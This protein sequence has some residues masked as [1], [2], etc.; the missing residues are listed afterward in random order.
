[1]EKHFVMKKTFCAAILFDFQVHEIVFSCEWNK[2]LSETPCAWKQSVRNV[3]RPSLS[4]YREK[5]P[6]CL[7]VQ[8]W[9]LLSIYALN[10]FCAS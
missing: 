9:N 8:V 3:V 6:A 1:M 5:K 4:S 10:S 2:Y 7:P